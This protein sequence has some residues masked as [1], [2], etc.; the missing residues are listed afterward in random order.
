[1][2]KTAIILLSVLLVIFMSS[3][4]TSGTVLVRYMDGK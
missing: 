2:R 4:D 1:M 3:C